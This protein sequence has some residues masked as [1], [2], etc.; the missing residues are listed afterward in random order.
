VHTGSLPQY[1][2]D[3]VVLLLINTALP[4]L[5]AKHQS[6]PFDDVSIC[7]VKTASEAMDLIERARP[8][9]IISN[10]I[11]QDLNGIELCRRIKS[12]AD[13]SEIPIILVSELKDDADEVSLKAG[14]EAGADDYF[15]ASTPGALLLKRVESLITTRKEKQARKQAEESLRQAE[16]QLR[17][18]QK[19]ESI[20]TLAGGIAHDFNN[21]LTAI[22]GYSELVLSRLDTASPLRTKVEEIHD[23]GER[24]ASLTRQLLA[25]SRKQALE[26]KVIDLNNIVTGMGKLLHRLIGEDIEQVMD[27]APE[28]G[29]VKADSGQIEQVIMNL[30]VNARDA[31]PEGG[32]LLILTANVEVGTDYARESLSVG[33]GQYVMLAV[34]DT[35]CG[36]DEETQ[37]RIFEPFFTTKEKGKGT[38][39]GLC[40][41]YGI[42]K[43][44]GGDIRVYSHP[45][46]GTTIKIY[47][48]RVEVVVEAPQAHCPVVAAATGSETIIVVED[49]ETVRKLA[50]VILH[51][52]GYTVLEARNADEALVICEQH[53]GP[54]HLMLTDIVMPGMSGRA[55]FYC[56]APLRPEMKV[57]YMSGYIEQAIL[58]QG[59]FN[60]PAPFLQ[61]PFKPNVLTRRVR[62]V[63][64]ENKKSES[65]TQIKP[66][67]AT[68][69][70]M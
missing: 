28:L 39:L 41:V 15:Q 30:A 4:K 48:P 22:I 54:I 65:S 12:N 50:R 49:E 2:G 57:L 66:Y 42:V 68:D 44:N 40:T 26:A 67:P 63:L 8:G 36:M 55:L 58:H 20:G 31:M 34:S 21:L 11:L 60:Q 59:V 10:V 33:P 17:H 24:A 1:I 45:G 37:Q 43:Q 9:L 64:D 5:D 27:L 19:M 51:L 13:T 69:I 29:Q 62:E 18:A 14:L 38:G 61:K 46:R 3:P 56:I 53:S 32:K 6:P 25:F 7:S 47:L 70:A 35:G 23:A 16:E 52:N